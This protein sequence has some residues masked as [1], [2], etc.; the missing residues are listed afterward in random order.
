MIDVSKKQKLKSVIGVMEV[1]REETSKYGIVD[2][3]FLD[4]DKKTLKMNKMVEKPKPENAP[5]HSPH[6]E[7]MF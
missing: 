3:H 2:G 6:Q 7:D 5:S 4:S 1:N